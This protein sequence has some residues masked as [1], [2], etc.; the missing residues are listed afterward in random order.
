MGKIELC[1]VPFSDLKCKTQSFVNNLWQEEWNTQTDNKL[2]QIRPSLC[3]FLPSVKGSR[4]E[5]TVLTRLH[6]G[7][8]YLT[9][10][11]LLRGERAPRCVSC[12]VQI[13]IKHLLL[14]CREMHDI[15]HKHFTASSMKTLFRDVP[16]DTI[17]Q[18][19][20]EAHIFN[21]LWS[22]YGES[23]LVFCSC[24][25]IFWTGFYHWRGGDPD[26]AW[27]LVGVEACSYIFWRML[28]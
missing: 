13:T 23:F 6:T 19:L 14:D 2:F 20:R 26:L 12:D 1:S 16:P 7:H 27:C 8:S 3:E 4:K 25:N 24:F 10:G 5:Q 21:R 22:Y 15:R 9:H 28:F 18:F 11:H 17:F